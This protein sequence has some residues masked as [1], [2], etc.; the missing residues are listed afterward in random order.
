MKYQCEHIK[1]MLETGRL[2]TKTIKKHGTGEVREGVPILHELHKD[3]EYL[4]TRERDRWIECIYCPTCGILVDAEE[5]SKIRALKKDVEISERRQYIEKAPLTFCGFC[6]QDIRPTAVPLAHGR[7]R[8]I[9]TCPICGGRVRRGMSRR[10]ID[11]A[12]GVIQGPG[13]RDRGQ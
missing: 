2:D 13:R 4:T 5:A 11:T 12:A 10:I 8:F 6:N 9:Y 1:Q 3:G 7:R